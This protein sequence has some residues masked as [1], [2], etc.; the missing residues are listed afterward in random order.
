MIPP[1]LQPL[2][3]ADGP[4]GQLAELFRNSGHELALVGGSVRDALLGRAIDDL[5]FATNARPERIK[6]VVGPWA[7]DIYLAGQRFGTIGAI[8][9]GHLYEVTTYRSEIYSDDSRNPDVSYS[10]D[11]AED[12]SRRDFTVN[13]MALRLDKPDEPELFD[14]HGGLEDLI[15]QTLR[16]PLDPHISFGDDPRGRL[17]AP[18]WRSRGCRS[19]RGAE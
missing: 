8:R 2:L 14:P 18:C 5:D 13:A 17:V 6:E 19:R 9:D 3:R 1:R 4:T 11:I 12:L 10:D 16:T 7:H 15:A